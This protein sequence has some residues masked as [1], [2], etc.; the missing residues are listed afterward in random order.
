MDFQQLRSWFQESPE[1]GVEGIVWHCGDGTLVK[2]TKRNG[3]HLRFVRH[4]AFW[5][6]SGRSVAVV[7]V[8]SSSSPGTEVAGWGDAPGWQ[9]AG[10]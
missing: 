1:G 9:V 7:S 10:R 3:K 8:G 4:E 5:L 2:V 6:A